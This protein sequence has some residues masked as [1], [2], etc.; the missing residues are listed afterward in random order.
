[1]SLTMECEV[2]SSTFTVL[3]PAR[4]LSDLEGTRE[5]VSPAS[6]PTSSCPS[7]TKSALMRSSRTWPLPPEGV[8][9][10][11]WTEDEV[12]RAG[13]AARPTVVVSRADLP[14]PLK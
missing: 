5:A 14:E 13:V 12:R 2:V 4:L 11:K 9:R 7:S 10:E 8:T 6:G 3:M 1:V